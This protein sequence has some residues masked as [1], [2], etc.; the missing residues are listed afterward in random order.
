MTHFELIQFIISNMCHLRSSFFNADATKHNYCD[1]V[2]QKLQRSYELLIT[3]INLNGFSNVIK[4][5]NFIS[6]I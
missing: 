6:K 3:R 5:Q 1:Q 2:A 4:N